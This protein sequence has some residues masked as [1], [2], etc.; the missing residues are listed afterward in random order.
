MR[1][2]IISS[3]FLPV[4]DGVSMAVLHRL[5]YLCD[6]NHTVLLLVPDY[7]PLQ[8]MYPN[9][10]TYVGSFLPR[11]EIV[12]LPSQPA[13]GLAFERDLKPK[14]YGHLLE[15]LRSFQ[16]D[17]IH[18]D[19]PERLSFCLLRKPGLAYARQ[20]Q[21]PCVGFFHTHYIDYL[22]D[23]VQWPTAILSG[24]KSVLRMIFSWIYN[25]YDATLV[26]SQSTAQKVGKMGI[27]NVVQGDFLG[28]DGTLFQSTQRQP[29]F[30]EAT[31]GLCHL[32]S[33]VKLLF[34]GR[35]T[36]DKG[37]GFTCTAFSQLVDVIDPTRISLIIVG[38][39]PLRNE[40][41]Q[42]LS[43]QLPHVHFLGR[44]APQQMP[45]LLAN[46]DIH[47]TTS[48]K[49]TTGL[50]VLEASAVGIPVLAP[51][52]GGVVDYIQ[53][54]QTGLLFNPH[55]QDD[56]VQKL[57]RLIES[58]TLRQDMGYQG[59]KS[60]AQYRWDIVTEN[61]LQCWQTYV[62]KTKSNVSL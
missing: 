27:R 55:D 8:E 48:L 31:Y 30:F 43:A 21:I 46:S 62:T 6:L 2:A 44:V 16:P 20:R 25:S 34:V 26:A 42:T 54:G 29:H 50:T 1:V 45:A 5:Q 38:D 32:E 28:F 10:R 23:Y 24:A 33:T 52:A 9:W 61:L 40:L 22:D 37:W 57:K 7:E 4:V 12:P 3:G 14:S 60:V 47:V 35:L 41:E 18:V 36:P 58:P 13:L 53:D 11:I 19:E 39:G 51:R 49:E 17:L 15:A 56:F 59:R